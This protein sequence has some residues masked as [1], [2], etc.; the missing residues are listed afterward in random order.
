MRLMRLTLRRF[1]RIPVG[2]TA[3]VRIKTTR[4]PR[5]AEIELELSEPP[6]GVTLQEV[7]TLPDGLELLLKADGD[8]AKA[9][10]AD[11]LIVEVFTESAPRPGGNAATQKRRV[12][13]GVLP[14]IPFEIV[15]E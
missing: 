5:L 3:Q 15:R 2:G 14:A 1:V 4:F 12:S 9:G 8:A 13:L 7:K 6:E 11:N 10:F